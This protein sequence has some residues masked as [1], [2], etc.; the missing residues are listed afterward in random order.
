MPERAPCQ[1]PSG[2]VGRAGWTPAGSRMTTSSAGIF[3]TI[4]PVAQSGPR[5]P[6]VTRLCR[7]LGAHGGVPNQASRGPSPGPELA[8]VDQ[9][10]GCPEPKPRPPL[11]TEQQSATS[12]LE[13][14]QH[15]RGASEGPR[16][17]AGHRPMA[18]GR[19]PRRACLRR[20]APWG[21]GR[22]CCPPR[23][24]DCGT[25]CDERGRRRPA[26]QVERAGHPF[27]RAEP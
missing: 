19:R 4:A 9:R 10:H 8:P 22:G 15:E 18:G 7:K 5:V 13:S 25:I 23:W 1:E 3:G 26:R 21:P 12:D 2:S 27:A 20:G 16:P 6:L 24:A 14:S 11:A 17:P